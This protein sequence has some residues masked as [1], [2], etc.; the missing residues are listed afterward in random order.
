MLALTSYID[1]GRHLISNSKLMMSAEYK[2]LAATVV[3]RFQP[4][5]SE[6]A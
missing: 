5:T 4:V 6:S 1:L 2:N 3:K